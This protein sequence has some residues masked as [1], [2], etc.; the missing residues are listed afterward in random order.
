MKKQLEYPEWTLIDWDGNTS[1]KLKC[2]R[3]SFGR[4]Y[5]SVG[6]GT[7]TNIVYSYGANSEFSL[8]STRWRESGT[9][10]EQQAMDIVDR[11]NGHYHYNNNNPKQIN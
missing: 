6:V 9:M 4:G 3:K 5:V 1:L 11:N 7:F 10:T 8:S 2:Y